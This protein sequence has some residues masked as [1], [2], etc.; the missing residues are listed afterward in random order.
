MGGP[1]AP[2]VVTTI[3]KKSIPNGQTPKGACLV[4]F[5]FISCVITDSKPNLAR[6]RFRALRGQTI[7]GSIIKSGRVPSSHVNRQSVMCPEL[8]EEDNARLEY[9]GLASYSFLAV[10][11][12]QCKKASCRSCLRL[13]TEQLKKCIPLMAWGR[14]I[15]L[16]FDGLNQG[17]FSWHTLRGASGW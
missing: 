1:I 10:V 7:V 5:S 9:S 13:L 8:S 14:G 15:R 4:S 2:C 12:T 6:E 16:V 11:P 17:H 3:G